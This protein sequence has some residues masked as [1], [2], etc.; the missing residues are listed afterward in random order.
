MNSFSNAKTIDES[1]RFHQKKYMHHD[2]PFNPFK[3][4]IKVRKIVP[5]STGGAIAVTNTNPALNSNQSYNQT[6]MMTTTTNNNTNINNARNVNKL[7]PSAPF[8]IIDFF[9]RKKT[10]SSSSADD[11]DTDSLNYETEMLSDS[12]LEQ[13]S[14]L[15]DADTPASFPPTPFSR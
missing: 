7:I 5:L 9:N 3:A 13:F 15:H 12:F 8:S 1:L 2:I 14:I 6:T 10:Q 11:Q 4:T